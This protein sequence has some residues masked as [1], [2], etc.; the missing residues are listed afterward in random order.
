MKAD[1]F[2]TSLIDD[3]LEITLNGGPFVD[4]RAIATNTGAKNGAQWLI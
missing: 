3:E 2:E 1:V 4:N